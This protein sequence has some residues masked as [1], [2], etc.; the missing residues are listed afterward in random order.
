MLEAP[1]LLSM[2]MYLIHSSVTVIMTRYLCR[3]GKGNIP[4]AIP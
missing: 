1:L 2:H 4:S 3:W